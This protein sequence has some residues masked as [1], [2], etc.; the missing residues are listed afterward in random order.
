LETSKTIKYDSDEDS[1][2]SG[3]ATEM[4]DDERRVYK[5]S[6]ALNITIKQARVI[7]QMTVNKGLHERYDKK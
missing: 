7:D 1:L 5:L 6:K 2:D 3:K 4:T